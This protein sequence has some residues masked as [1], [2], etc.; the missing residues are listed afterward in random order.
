MV[1]GMLKTKIFNSYKDK[2][3]DMLKKEEEEIRVKLLLTPG[4]KKLLKKLASLL[5][6]MEDIEGAIKIYEKLIDLDSKNSDFFGFL[7]YLH[8]EKE[9]LKK[10]S[11]YLEMAS[12]LDPRSP[13][14]Y[15]LLGNTYSRIGMI[16][17][18]TE[19]Y[20]LAIFLDLDIYIAHK[21]FAK[22]YEEMGRVKKALKEYIAAYEIDPRDGKILKNIERLKEIV[23]G[24][25]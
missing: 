19:N 14:L 12:D 20:E 17:E 21:D 9:E 2:T 8:Y 18:A 10:A 6:Y 5:Y 7:G 24:K 4:D 16:R 13:F 15:F 22:K 11:E 23:G 25:S 1:I 3:M